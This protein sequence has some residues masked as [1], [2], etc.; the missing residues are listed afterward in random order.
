MDTVLRAIILYFALLV[1]MRLAG[2]RTFAQMTPFDFVLLL[3][4][5][6]AVQQGLTGEDFSLTGS[7]LLVSTLVMLDVL[8]SYVKQWSRTAD[9]WIDSTPVLLV[10]NGKV[11]KK[12]MNDVRVT[13]EDILASARELRGLE[14]M[15]QVKYAVLETT[16]KITVI[17][18]AD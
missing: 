3:I 2:K 11:L 1:L 17:A 9:K 6:E 16:G 5:G 8:M 4:I 15:D 14:R 18:T 10:D 7:L 13:E 12:R